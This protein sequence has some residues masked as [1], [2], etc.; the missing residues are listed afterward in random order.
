MFQAL[1]LFCIN[2]YYEVFMNPHYLDCKK[3]ISTWTKLEYF[4]QMNEKKY[5]NESRVMDA[6]DTE[7][8]EP[9]R[10]I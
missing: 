4:F 8:I 9:Q 10:A 6:S 7:A 1:A 5:L 3:A 2:I